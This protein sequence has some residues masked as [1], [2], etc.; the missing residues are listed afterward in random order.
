MI[1]CSFGPFQRQAEGNSTKY[2]P[3]P[4]EPQVST[5]P[6]RLIGKPWLGKYFFLHLLRQVAP[7]P[8][9]ARCPWA[10]TAASTHD[11][12]E[13][14]KVLPLTWFWV[15]H[16]AA[17]I[18]YTPGMGATT[19]PASVS[20]PRTDQTFAYEKDRAYCTRLRHSAAEAS[21]L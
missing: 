14:S 3:D 11:R 10:Q 2:A 5:I 15:S 21:H 9:Q 20:K 19:G 12:G 13:P 18:R 7:W 8:W 1:S 4:S 16:D 6:L 17:L